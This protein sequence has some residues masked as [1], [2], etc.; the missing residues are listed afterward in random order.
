MQLLYDRFYAAAFLAN[1]DHRLSNLNNGLRK[2]PTLIFL[3]IFG[4]TH[5]S[6]HNEIP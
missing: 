5:N 1:F 3:V 4:L 6:Y 2:K